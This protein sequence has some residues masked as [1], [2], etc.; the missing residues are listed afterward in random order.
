MMKK[1]KFPSYMCVDV[2]QGA[3]KQAINV[4][5]ICKSGAI[6]RESFMNS[7]EEYC[8]RN[9]LDSL[10]LTDPGSYSLSC[11]E[12]KRDAR[13]KLIFFTKKNPKAIASYG[14]TEP[15]CGPCQRTK[16]RDAQKKD[17]HVDWWLYCD[18]RPWEYFREVTFDEIK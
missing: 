17:S 2:P 7:Y 10:D 4:Y 8:K 1:E 9:D 16:E 14:R 5:R 13:R 3:K 15:C 6:D 11:F 12:K 18:A